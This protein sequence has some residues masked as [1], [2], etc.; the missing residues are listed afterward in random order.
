M[1]N[2][3]IGLVIGWFCHMY[4]DPII[5]KIKSLTKKED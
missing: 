3:I 2:F 4:K 1:V 5:K